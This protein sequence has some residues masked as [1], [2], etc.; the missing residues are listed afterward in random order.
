MLV[1]TLHCLNWGSGCVPCHLLPS[2]DLGVG[3]MVENRLSQPRVSLECPTGALPDTPRREAPR[4]PVLQPRLP[5]EGL[6]GAACEAPHGRETFQMLQV[7]PWLRR[8]RHTQPAPAHQRSE[9]QVAGEGEGWGQLALTE[10]SFP[11]GRGLPAG[12]GGVAGI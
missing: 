7:W 1:P 4:V 12:S 3:A 6:T 5:G 9:P 11:V 2:L 10:L 8:A